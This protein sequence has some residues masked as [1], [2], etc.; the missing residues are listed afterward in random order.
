MMPF[1]LLLAFFS[2]PTLL[3]AAVQGPA[4]SQEDLSVLPPQVVEVSEAEHARVAEAFGRLPLYFVA[5]QGQVDDKQVGFYVKGA[6][7]TLYFT[8]DGITFALK[9]AA[10]K[11]DQADARVAGDR[12]VESDESEEGGEP[13][14]WSIKLDFL[15]A[16]PEVKLEGE[17]RQH[18][19]FS[20]FTGQPEDWHAAIPTFGKVVYRDLWPGIDLVYSGT[21]NALKY[22]FVVKPG[23][24]PKQIRMAYRGVSALNIKKT[25]ELDVSTPVGGF[26]DGVPVAWQVIEGE[27]RMVSMHYALGA[28]QE[29][30]IHPYHFDLGTYDP[31]LP[32]ILDP[33]ILVYC[34]YIGGA[35]D[36]WGTGIAVDGQGNA[37]VTGWTESDESSFPVTVGPDLTFNSGIYSTDAFVARVN[38]QGTALD[39]CGY[40]GGADNDEGLSIAVDDQSNAYVTGLTRSDESSF[41]VTVGPDLTFNGVFDTFVA[42]VNPQGTA[43]DYCGYIGGAGEDFGAGIAVDDQGNAYVTGNT[44]SDESSFPVTVG[45]DLTYNGGNQDAF[46]ARVNTQGTALDYCG[47][48]GG[49]AGYEFGTGIAVD[50]QGN[51]YV[52]GRTPS[53]ES[54]FPVTVGPDLTYNGFTDAFVARV[55]AQGTGLDYCGYIGG[56][57]RDIGTGIAVD[58]H[59]NVYVTGSTR[60]DESSFPVTVGP[61]LTYNGLSNGLPDAFVARVNAQG[62]GL[63]YCGYIGGIS[64]DG[65]AGITVDDQGNVY[66][67]GSTWSDE[68]SFPVTV[69][70]YLTY[71]GGIDAFV[72][73]VNPQG[74]GLDY[75]GYIGGADPDWGTGIAVDAQGNAY[76]TGETWSVPSSFPVTVGPDLTYNGHHDAFVTKIVAFQFTLSASPDPLIAGQT[77][78]FSVSGASPNTAIW[79]AYSLDG[80][81]STSVPLLNVSLDLANPVQAAGPTVSDG[82]GELDWNI[83]IPPGASGLNVWLQAL[84][85]DKISNVVATSIF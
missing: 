24:D 5:N 35:S 63:D 20:Y 46:V 39:Y 31:S 84:Q 13:S 59:G 45:P 62:T 2:F 47:Y 65:G 54:S 7:K 56:G 3:I 58:A 68:S 26:E 71:N 49:G 83:M 75:C 4:K 28:T 1:T 9:G 81:G 37:Y 19:V 80:I 78:T 21:V 53:D 57:D 43:L 73:R 12:R 42:R 52:T 79:L 33:V 55:N 10:A 29:D 16:N 32:L 76:V 82:Q 61:D 8:P 11:N 30:G 27:K 85:S 74:T 64:N 15:G 48:I 69:G 34:G 25:G 22:E 77:A 38:A 14:R 60:S 67:T 23:A 44:K 6:D 17:D 50:G 41:P 51:A 72:A 70:P 40:I 36:D 66:V 18:A